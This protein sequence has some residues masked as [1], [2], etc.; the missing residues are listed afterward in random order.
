MVNL[1]EFRS[2]LSLQ[3]RASRFVWGLVWMTMFRPSP[4]LAFFWRTW[5][6]RSF[7]AKIGR[8][9]RIHNSARVFLPSLLQL[10]DR[11]I[12]GPDTDLYCVAK[13]HIHHDSMVSQYAYLCAASHDYSHPHL[14]LIAEPIVIQ[15]Q[16]WVC[17][18]AFIGPG[19]IIGSRAVVGARSV[20]VKNVQS[21]HVVAGN[22]ARFIK[23]RTLRE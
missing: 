14:P 13:I 4:R 18:G 10:D 22:P 2:N 7:G 17:A 20:V 3:N 5:L 16:A 11:V 19:V 9:V 21:D 15:P 8:N 1:A 12:I 23:L 6:L